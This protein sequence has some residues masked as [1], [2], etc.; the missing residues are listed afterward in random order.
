[1]SRDVLNTEKAVLRRNACDLKSKILLDHQL[2]Y[3][4]RCLYFKNRHQYLKK[5]VK[6]LYTLLPNT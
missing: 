6:S 2:P 5:Y 3:Y 1:M 4:F